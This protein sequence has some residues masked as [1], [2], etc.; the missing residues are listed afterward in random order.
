MSCCVMV[1][2]LWLCFTRFYENNNQLS[3]LCYIYYQIL[4]YVEMI[5]LAAGYLLKHINGYI[6]D[7]Q[8]H[9]SCG[10]GL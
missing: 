2:S 6:E 10:S 8:L 1:H 4:S 3:Q 7:W 9:N 5:C